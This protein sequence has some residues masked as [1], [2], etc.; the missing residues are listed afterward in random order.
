MEDGLDVSFS[1]AVFTTIA[2]LVGLD[3][4]AQLRDVNHFDVHRARIT[5]ELFGKIIADIHMAA[6]V[7]GLSREQEDE[8]FRS[9]VISFEFLAAARVITILIIDALDIPPYYFIEGRLTGSIRRES[10]TPWTRIR[11]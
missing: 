5:N 3:L 7:Y 1:R 8:E 11:N 2:P 4:S 10:W 6:N 9:R